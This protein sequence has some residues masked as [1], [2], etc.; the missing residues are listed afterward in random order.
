MAPVRFDARNNSRRLWRSRRRKSRSAPKG[1]V[2]FCFKQ[3]FSLP[4]IAQILAGMAFLGAGESGKNLPAASKFAE[5][6]FQQGS[7]DS[8]GLLEFSELGSGTVRAVLVFGSDGFSG[9]QGLYA[10]ILRWKGPVPALVSETWF[11]N[12]SSSKNLLSVPGNQA[13]SKVY[14]KHAR[15]FM[16]TLTNFGEP[17]TPLSPYSREP[18]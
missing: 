11:Q 12:G 9:E 1:E 7:L 8:H 2:D 5:K 10:S 18:P 3:P 16:R 14:P 17:T 15:A 6:P 13:G 4:R